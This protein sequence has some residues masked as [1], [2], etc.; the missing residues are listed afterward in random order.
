MV[1]YRRSRMI[2]EP[3]NEIEYLAVSGG[4]TAG[5]T[6]SGA[7][8]ADG[9]HGANVKQGVV[10]LNA[11]AYPITVGAGAGGAGSG[12]GSKGNPGGASSIGSLVVTSVGR[13]ALGA[14]NS[15]TGAGGDSDVATHS[16]TSGANGVTSSI[17]GTS[18]VY[19]SGGG[20]FLGVAGSAGAEA[21]NAN[22]GG[23]T[24]GGTSGTAPSGRV[25][26]RYLTGS[27][28]ATGGT[29]TTVGLYTVHTFTSNGTFTVT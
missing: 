19:G 2:G 3:T 7:G 8:N 10:S 24:T 4:D 22:Q 17:D 20:G 1:F 25:V 27:M 15:A 13:Q 28:S 6:N 11:G 9:G 12:S 21:G 5:D 18:R 16:G 23:G 14:I 29:I 26:I